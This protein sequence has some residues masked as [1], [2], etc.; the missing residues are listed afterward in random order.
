MINRLCLCV[1]FVC[2][3]CVVCG[4]VICDLCVV[5]VCQENN[6]MTL[7]SV[8]KSQI[9]CVVARVWLLVW[10]LGS[11]RAV[12]WLVVVVVCLVV[13]VLCLVVVVRGSW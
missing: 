10:L 4:C 9:S 12:L 5:G 6:D 8:R 11:C 7:C 13:V 3:L 2:A 1:C